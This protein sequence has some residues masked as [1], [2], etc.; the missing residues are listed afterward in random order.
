MIEFLPVIFSQPGK[1]ELN[2]DSVYPVHVNGVLPSTYLVCDGVGGSNRGEVAS[3]MTCQSVSEHLSKVNKVRK[4]DI[5]NA[6]RAAE[7]QL[8]DHSAKHPECK[9]MATTLVGFH[10]TSSD[11]GLVFWVGDSRLYHV[12]KNKVLFETK[13]HSLVQMMIDNGQLTVEE[14][15]TYPSRNI[16]LQAVG[17][18]DRHA[19]AAVHKLTDIQPGDYLLLL[20]DGILEGCTIQDLTDVLNQ[21][22]LSEAG[23]AIQAK[24]S[25]HSRDNFSLIAL[26]AL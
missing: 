23:D 20:S 1:R 6:I 15:A 3:A 4:G 18:S 17:D 25:Q 11:S 5:H 14:A 22:N 21:M 8:S 26:Q 13:D 7:N 9:G 16:I 19:E 2:E 10:P 12:R 24:C